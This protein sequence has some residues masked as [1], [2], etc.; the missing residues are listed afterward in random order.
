MATMELAIELGTSNTA[1]FLEG[2]GLVLYEP[3]VVALSQNAKKEKIRAF[4]LQAIK[5][6]SEDQDS[7][8]LVSPVDSGL[9]LDL[10]T[11]TYM[12]KEHLKRLISKKAIFNPKFRTILNVPLGLSDKERTS[13]ESVCFRSGISDLILVD[14]IL[15]SAVGMDLPVSSGGYFCVV[16]IG[17][18]R[19]DIAVISNCRVVEGCSI[20]MG[21][22]LMDVAIADCIAETF[23]VSI[24]RPVAIKTKQSIASLYSNDTLEAQVTGSSV[25]DKKTSSIVVQSADIYSTILPYYEKISDGIKSVLGNCPA[26]VV[27]DIQTKGIYLCGGSSQV[28][29]LDLLYK[30]LLSANVWLVENPI[31]TAI[32]G[33]GKLLHYKELL[34]DIMQKS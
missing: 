11:C 24:S 8:V 18:G 21:G 9:L 2:T 1:I 17:G 4:G 13:F 32:V 29:G 33:A 6:M 15:S 20:N 25:V 27:Q 22:N 30:D 34:L 23:G 12:L 5:M 14:S 3:S 28:P 26:Q 7:T 10:D 19:T 31:Y 16:N